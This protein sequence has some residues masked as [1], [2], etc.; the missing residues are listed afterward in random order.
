[1]NRHQDNDFVRHMLIDQFNANTFML[2]RLTHMC[3]RL[4]CTI[5]VTQAKSEFLC[6]SID[7]VLLG[8]NGENYLAWGSYNTKLLEPIDW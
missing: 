5:E 2:R 3:R 1:M 6:V 8:G 7:G 4:D